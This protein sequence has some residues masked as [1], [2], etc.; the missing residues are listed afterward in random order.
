MY[1]INNERHLLQIFLS[2]NLTATGPSVRNAKITQ[3]A[4]TA[5]KNE[6]TLF[7][8]LLVARRVGKIPKMVE[9]KLLRRVELG[10]VGAISTLNSAKIGIPWTHVGP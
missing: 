3:R 8:R 6:I 9:Q 4:G 7:E 10:G 2:I 5:E 1:Y